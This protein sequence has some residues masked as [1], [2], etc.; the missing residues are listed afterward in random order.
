M[1]QSYLS[2]E[3]KLCLKASESSFTALL[4]DGTVVT[5]GDPDCC[6]ACWSG[7]VCLLFNLCLDGFVSF[8]TLPWND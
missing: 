5:W 7:K 1:I 8:L 6:L 3:A 4:D 2:L